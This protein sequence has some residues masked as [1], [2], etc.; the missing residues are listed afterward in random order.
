MKP[1]KNEKS[2]QK[3]EAVKAYVDSQIDILRKYGTEVRPSS[4]KYKEI[5]RQVERASAS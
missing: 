3:Q 4:R 5:V 2:S 1:T